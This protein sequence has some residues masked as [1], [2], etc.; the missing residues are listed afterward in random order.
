[1]LLRQKTNNFLRLEKWS[2]EGW[3][4]LAERSDNRIVANPVR[5]HGSIIGTHGALHE[6]EPGCTAAYTAATEWRVYYHR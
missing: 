2:P 3:L 1:M 4:L 6:E 5:A